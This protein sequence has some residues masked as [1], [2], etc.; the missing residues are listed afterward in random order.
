[1][2][3]RFVEV[4]IQHYNC[5][6]PIIRVMASVKNWKLHCICHN[7][8]KGVKELEAGAEF[9]GKNGASQAAVA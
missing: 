9:F 1:M 7:L 2:S 8:A 4:N 6:R 5:A 3:A